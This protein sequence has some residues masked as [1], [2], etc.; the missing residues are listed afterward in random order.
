MAEHHFLF[1]TILIG[2]SGVGK[3]SIITRYVDKIYTEN[4]ISTIGV[5]F[6]IKTIELD[7]NI[8]KLQIWD[9]AGQERFRAI[10]TSYYRGSQ[11]ILI[12]FDVTDRESFNE[13]PS[14]IQEIKKKCVKNPL[15]VV[16]GNKIDDKDKLDVTEDEVKNFIKKE[17][18]LKDCLYR[19]ISAKENTNIDDIFITVVKK[20][21]ER[22]S[23][24]EPDNEKDL[25]DITFTENQ[26]RCC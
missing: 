26:K 4:F 1:K 7:G 17:S 6:K 21:M 2:N 16:L 9:T 23:L 11:C 8:V 14:W 5:D 12:V 20:L 3:T 18:F 24:E 25:G 22:V 19:F 10:T 15:I 13:I